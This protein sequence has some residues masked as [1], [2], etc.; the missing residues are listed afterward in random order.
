MAKFILGFAAGFAAVFVVALAVAY[1]GGFPVDGTA[2]PFEIETRHARAA[3]KARLAKDADGIRNP[4]TADE[5][6]L[7]EGLRIYRDNC[8][9]CHGERGKPSPWGTT[10]FFPRVPQLDDH[11][12]DLTPGQMFVA[13]KNGIR[14]TGMG[15]WQKLMKEDDIWKVVTF[16]GHVD[17]A[18]PGK[19]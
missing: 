16:L 14:Y 19:Q 3:L 7:R 13:V 17:R 11:P 12:S 15:A 9:G 10:S 6:T 5:P 8:S 18:P 2:E 1:A 4:L